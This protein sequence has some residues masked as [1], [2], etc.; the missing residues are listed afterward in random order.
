MLKKIDDMKFIAVLYVLKFMLP[1]LSTVSKT[2]QNGESNFS[3]IKPA[4]ENNNLQNK[5]LC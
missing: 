5:E 4:I 1:Y 2:F 3:R